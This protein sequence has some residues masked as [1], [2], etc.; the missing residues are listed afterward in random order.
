MLIPELSEDQ[1][2]LLEVAYLGFRECATWPTSAYV[3]TILDHD[4][5][6]DFEAVLGELPANIVIPIHGY[7]DQSPVK[8]TVAGLSFVDAASSDLANFL[9]LLHA[10]TERESHSRP[11]PNDVPDVKLSEEDELQI[12]GHQLANDELAR[13]LEI[14]YVEGINAGATGLNE[15][16]K[17]SLGFNRWVRPYRGVEGVND[18]LA[19]RPE[20]ISPT[21]APPPPATPYIF[22]LMPFRADWSKNLKD[23]IDQACLESSRQFAGLRWERADEITETGRITDQIVTAI[24]RADALI[25]DITETNPNVL[26]ELGYGDALGKPI[27]VLNQDLD[28]TPFDIKDWRQIGYE[29]DDLAMLRQSLGDFLVAT[30]RRQGFQA[31]EL[32]AGS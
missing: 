13:A 26:F 17:W 25:A 6:V 15:D 29:L 1:R 32:P 8:L 20:P 7:A 3:D 31:P 9:A 28:E 11:G 30:L 24:E 19:R 22:I 16:G 4:Y 18:Y 10:A 21:W 2:R 27:I 23:V 5:S 14:T 12:W